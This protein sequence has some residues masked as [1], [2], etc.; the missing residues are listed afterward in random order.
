MLSP[1]LG[2]WVARSEPR[3]RQEGRRR[4][5]SDK[6]RQGSLSAEGRGLLPKN[7]PDK[8]SEYGAGLRVGVEFARLLFC[9]GQADGPTPGSQ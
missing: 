9:E 7:C 3:T 2:S 6:P 4:A 5:P 1:R 8:G